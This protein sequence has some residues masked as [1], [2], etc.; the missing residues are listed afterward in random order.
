MGCMVS[1]LGR[2]VRLQVQRGR[3]KPG[4]RGARVYDPEPLL[5][6][7][8]LQVTDVGCLGR[9]GGAWL[10]DVHHRDHPD[11]R[12]RTES[13]V[14][15]LTTAAY[16]ALRARYGPHLADGVA[17]ENVLVDSDLLLSDLEPAQLTIGAVRLHPVVVAEPCVEFARWCA[18]L[19]PGDSTRGTLVDLRGG[20]RGWIGIPVEP[21]VVAMGDIVRLG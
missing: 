16:R 10:V 6:V 3:L 5:A 18:R 15:L 19:E 2:V 14:S 13:P 11:T 7:D 20:A 1:E 4:E 21:A 17:G 12:H 8:A 9:S